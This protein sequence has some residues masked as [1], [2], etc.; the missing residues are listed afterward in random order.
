VT[1]EINMRGKKEHR[2]NTWTKGLLKKKQ[3]TTRTTE[4]AFVCN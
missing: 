3:A 2:G 4:P 1:E